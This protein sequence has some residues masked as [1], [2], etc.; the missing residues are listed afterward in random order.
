MAYNYGNDIGYLGNTPGIQPIYNNIKRNQVYQATH[1]S[2]D[3]RTSYNARSYISFSFGGTQIEDL[4][5]IAC[6]DGD[7]MERQLTANFHDLTSS[8]DVVDGQF[9]WG[10]YYDNNQMNFYLA[11]DGMTQEN[12]EDFI[13]LFAPGS[14]REL[15]LAEHPNRAIMAR[16][17]TPPV[18]NVIPFQEEVDLKVNTMDRNTITALYKG[19][20]HLELIMDEPFWYGKVNVLGEKV[21]NEELNADEWVANWTDANNN[22]VVT[23]ND[24]D[25]LR[26]IYEDRIPTMVMLRAP[27]FLGNDLV[28][29]YNTQ[30][31]RVDY[32]LVGAHDAP[33]GE[34]EEGAIIITQRELQ[35]PEV[36]KAQVAIEEMSDSMELPGDGHG[37]TYLYY[38][39]TAPEKPI[40][41]FIVTG[42]INDFLNQE[43]K[44]DFYCGEE[45][46]HLELK[47]PLI[48]QQYKQVKEAFSQWNSIDNTY[49]DIRLFIRANIT[50]PVIKK[51][52]LF[53]IDYCQANSIPL[54]ANG[55]VYLKY[56]FCDGIITNGA[57]RIV[58]VN[59]S[60]AD[61]INIYELNFQTGELN[62][63][64]QYRDLTMLSNL[65]QPNRIF[66]DGSDFTNFETGIEYHN[67]SCPMIANLEN[68][69]N[70]LY[71]KPIILRERNHFSSDGT[72]RF[73]N[74]ND[75]L[76]SYKIVNN[77]NIDFANISI[78]FSNRYY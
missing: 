53:I 30:C 69:N 34:N 25:A 35:N 57:S 46:Q 62:C 20:I 2:N 47:L 23:Y 24:K 12:L 74:K 38:S 33:L 19:D 10:T 7:R 61:L 50:H 63:T 43:I 5:L 51:W 4:N 9:Y 36:G 31:A 6:V 17:A 65:D 59:I 68:I 60:E 70:S 75:K 54:N 15:I 1:N 66:N 52:S 48:Y 71:S 26:I 39:G 73:Y 76:L 45:I 55:I 14:T 77:S 3:E 58:Q 32:A 41:R 11:T 37:V 56:I 40:I 78:E 16:V 22:K 67:V 42:K 44:L 49:R 13:R 72:I 64:F 8:Y 29:R 27:C 18:M 21:Y 28:Y